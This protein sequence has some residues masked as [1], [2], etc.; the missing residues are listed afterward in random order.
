MLMKHYPKWL[1]CVTACL[2]LFLLLDCSVANAEL[3]HRTEPPRRACQS[4]FSRLIIRI[5]KMIRPQLLLRAI[6]LSPRPAR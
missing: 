2:L 6:L 3:S 5:R 4:K 1:Q